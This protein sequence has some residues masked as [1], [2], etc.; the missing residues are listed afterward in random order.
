MPQRLPQRRRQRDPTHDDM[1]AP[2]LL[3][4]LYGAADA[5]L[6]PL[7]ST[8]SSKVLALRGGSTGQL[9]NA[10][11]AL[12]VVSGLQ[13]WTY[14]EE[15]LG[16]YGIKS[17]SESES[18]IM[19]CVGGVQLAS[20]VRPSLS[21]VAARLTHASA[22]AHTLPQATLLVGK[23]DIDKAMIA[24]LY[25]H[26]FV[27]LG[28]I[29]I[30]ENLKVAKGP[31]LATV[32]VMVALAELGRQGVIPANVM[33]Y[34][35]GAFYILPGLVEVLSPQTTF[36]S[37]GFALSPLGKTLGSNFGAIKVSA[38]LFLAVTKLTGKAGLGLAAAAAVGVLNCFKVAASAG[39]TGIEKPGIIVWALLQSVIA[40]LAYKG[41]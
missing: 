5:K 7:R 35:V 15:T 41:A 12:N 20:A 10:M 37:F 40:I 8:S 17:V 2:L 34:V 33:A 29:P 31:V 27:C 24:L 18:F 38:A 32:A 6:L 39:E 14:P 9:I 23:T 16:L 21:R 11:S 22:T 36:E 28:N 19:R 1:K 30:I 25:V 26:S 4:A 13:A 3:A